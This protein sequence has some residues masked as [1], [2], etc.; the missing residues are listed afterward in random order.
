MKKDAGQSFRGFLYQRSAPPR[1]LY[2]RSFRLH[3]VYLSISS[4]S[5]MFSLIT[6]SLSE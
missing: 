1:M 2:G 6:S 4:S 3:L 5:L